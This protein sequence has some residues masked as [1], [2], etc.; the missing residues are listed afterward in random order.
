VNLLLQNGA[1]PNAKAHPSGWTPLHDASYSNSSASLNLLLQAGAY[2]DARASSGA[3]PL[4]FAAQ[5]DAPDSAQLLL[6]AG[7]STTIRC[8]GNATV[9]NV[10]QGNAQAQ[11]P[12]SRFSGYTP[13]H[14][15]AHY[16]ASNAAKFILMHN[17][18]NILHIPDLSGKIP[19]HIAVLRGSDAVLKL[20]FSHG[21]AL[22]PTLSSHIPKK[23]VQSTKPW[24]CITQQ[25][26][27]KCI[28][29]LQEASLEWDPT[30]HYLFS[31]I[32]RSCI[33]NIL[34]ISKQWEQRRYGI[35]LKEVWL[36]ILSFCGRGW[37]E[38]LHLQSNHHVTMH[39]DVMIDFDPEFEQE[40]S[41]DDFQ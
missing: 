24:N 5:E 40:E 3:T 30:R 35:Y 29:L 32:D 11:Q 39:D 18:K 27:S 9:L 41:D 1:D 25:R 15:C 33:W 4:C 7:A 26:I 28:T 6:A 12:A 38:T 10:V 13:L 2:V 23:P 31:P 14:Y 20:L 16:N 37:F 22:P 21:A 34:L 19:V 8:C 36:E 17:A